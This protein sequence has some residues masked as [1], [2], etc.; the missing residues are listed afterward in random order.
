M[1]AQPGTQ[2]R[3]T[4]QIRA[5]HASDT[6]TTKLNPSSDSDMLQ[7]A[8]RLCL[9]DRL[10]TAIEVAELFSVPESWIRE[11]TRGGG[12]ASSRIAAISRTRSSLSGWLVIAAM[13]RLR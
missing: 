1:L 7:H 13:S 11:H 9:R 2:T 4:N 8:E 12:D 5:P 3:L 6:K 10:L